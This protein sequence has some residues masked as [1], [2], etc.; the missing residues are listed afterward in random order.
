MILVLVGLVGLVLGCL[1][2]FW[3]GYEDARTELAGRGIAYTEKG[4]RS[5]ARSGD[6][7]VLKLFV[8]AGMSV[9]AASGG[10]TALHNAAESDLEVVKYLVEQ[11][12]DVDADAVILLDRW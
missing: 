4:F 6:L 10:W 11:G 9:N 3:L 5:A 1:V 8:E 12:A 7:E 2:G